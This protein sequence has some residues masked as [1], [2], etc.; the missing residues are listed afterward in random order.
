MPIRAFAGST[1]AACRKAQ[2]SI[3]MVS[4]RRLQ[5]SSSLAVRRSN[6]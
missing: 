4:S 6:A 5:T 2:R 1:D 3:R